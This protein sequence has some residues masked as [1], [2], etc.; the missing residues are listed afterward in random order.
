MPNGGPGRFISGLPDGLR[1]AAVQ[2]SPQRS[3]PAGEGVAEEYRPF[4]MAL[5][6]A[7]ERRPPF[8]KAA[9]AVVMGVTFNV[10]R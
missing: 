1:D 9:A 10:A 5:R 6:R 2:V 8:D 4:V 3:E 7:I